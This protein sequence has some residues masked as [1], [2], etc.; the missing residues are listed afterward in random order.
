M[1]G[2]ASIW[3]QLARPIMAM[4]PM[5]EVTDA[6]FRQIINARGK[7]DL[8]FTE[9]VS[10]DGLCSERGRKHL[11]RDLKYSA[12]ER[13]IIA[14]IF[15][16]NPE[17]MRGAAALVRELGFDGVDINM[18]CP[19]RVITKTG[20]GSAL[21]RT[22][23]LAKEVIAA[24]Q[25]GAEHLPVSVKT[26]IGW[27]RP[28]IEEWM[29]HLIDACP[30]AITMHLRTTK[31]Q[32]AV[33]A[34]WEL[35]HDV[36]SAAHG[37]GIPV[38]GNGDVQSLAAADELVESSG[39]DGIMLGRAIYGNP[40][41]FDRTRDWSDIT[42]GEKFATMVEHALLFENVFAETK[43]FLIMRKHLRGYASGFPGSKD[44]RV[45]LQ[46]IETAVDVIDAIDDAESHLRRLGYNPDTVTV[47]DF[48]RVRPA[49]ESSAPASG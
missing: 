31:E 18:G 46:S 33:P 30:A 14:Q 6:A 35:V 48:D 2:T 16:V 3:T 24:T 7:P 42:L 4:A 17:T 34:H 47:R 15:G 25:E 38:L 11:L 22:P 43:S 20:C 49:T 13:P 37:S 12:P 29:R 19:V 32:S 10:A 45:A 40:W 36:V 23:E 26:R 39:L 9:F 21:I 41:L 28:I 27:S 1:T 5:A 8:F 44:L